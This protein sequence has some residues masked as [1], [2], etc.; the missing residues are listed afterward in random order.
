MSTTYVQEGDALT[1]TAPTGGVVSGTPCFVGGRFVIP[2][3]TAAQTLP[4]DADIEGVHVLPK[5]ASQAWA[6]GQRIYW[7]MTNSKADSGS[8]S[9]PY[10]GIAT[11]TIGSGSGET[12]G[13]VK[14]DPWSGTGSI[15]H[16]RARVV[17]ADV[18]AGKVLVPAV[19]GRRYR[20]LDAAAIAYGGAATTGTTVDILGTVTTARKL[21]AFTQASLTQSTVVRAGATGGTVLAD[22]ASFTQND[23]NTELKVLKTGSDFTVATGIDFLISYAIDPA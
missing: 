11:Q 7:D 1:L 15:Q 14:L 8:L 12:T 5:T 18:N 4:F 2:K 17:I 13:Y 19:P 6:E 9:G 3:T 20:L 10:I 16:L 21:V 22:G 23:A